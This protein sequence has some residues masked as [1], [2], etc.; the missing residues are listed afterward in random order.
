M[1][2]GQDKVRYAI[3]F[4]NPRDLRTHC[5]HGE[6][7]DAVCKC[8]RQEFDHVVS[9]YKAAS[10]WAEVW[11]PVVVRVTRKRRGLS[12]AKLAEARRIAAF[13]RDNT[14]HYASTVLDLCHLLGVDNG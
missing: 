3:R 6:T 10:G 8:G 5:W 12:A 7:G 14:T 4:R 11:N 9:A 13:L 2:D 1:S